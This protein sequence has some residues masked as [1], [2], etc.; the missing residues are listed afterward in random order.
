MTLVHRGV[1]RLGYVR[2]GL[3]DAA[4][5]KSRDFY[6]RQLGLLETASSADRLMYRCWHE[7]Y[8][9]TL[10]IERAATPGLVEIGLQLRDEGDVGA[11]QRKIQEA[12]TATTA[13]GADVV[14]QGLGRSFSFEL[15]AGPRL[16]LFADLRQ[17]G[18]VTGYISPD[19]VAPRA[20]RGTPA[21]LHLNHIAFTSP[22]PERCMEACRSLLGFYVS[23]QI[24]EEDGRV[25]SAL[26][27][28]MMKNVGGQE[29]AI[30]PGDSVKLHHIAFSKEDSSDILADGT[31]LRCDRVDIDLL[32]PLRQ[33]Y[34]NTFSLYFRDPSGVRLE[35]CSGGR[36]TEAHPDFQPV[37]W[38][39]RN[40][41][42][43]L[44]YYDEEMG[45][46]FLQPSL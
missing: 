36:M 33:P 13:A 38:S 42:K 44:S 3:E 7:P 8:Q 32:G 5:A 26:L 34:G 39:A 43:A 41:K 17:T 19:W 20:M 28:R 18:Y 11:Y 27:F 21:P 12:G 40:I 35:L 6:T 4:F 10:V 25:V 46:E 29:L 1:Q 23:E 24:V 30:F 2:I 45:D 16:R 9:C 22:D 14:M 15:P 31:N 37:S